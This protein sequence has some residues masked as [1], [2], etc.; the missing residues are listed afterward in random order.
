MTTVPQQ[1]GKMTVL[2]ELYVRQRLR[3][4]E[5]ERL[6]RRPHPARLEPR[7]P[8]LAPAFAW[9]GGALRRLGEVLESWGA[10][11]P[12]SAADGELT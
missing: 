1:K 4:L 12:E 6:T 7:R 11:R 2:Y 10:A 3:E 5:E 9:S 8:L